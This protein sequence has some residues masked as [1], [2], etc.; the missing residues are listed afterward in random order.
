[1]PLKVGTI[2]PRS[3]ETPPKSTT[4]PPCTG[5]A[6]WYTA[7]PPAHPHNKHKP[8]TTISSRTRKI[9]DLPR[10]TT[11]AAPLPGKGGPSYLPSR[12]NLPPALSQLHVKLRG[13]EHSEE[14]KDVT[15][16][17]ADDLNHPS[18]PH[19]GEQRV[20]LALAIGFIPEDV[21]PRGAA[22]THVVT[23]G[24]VRVAGGCTSRGQT[25]IRAFCAAQL[26]GADRQNRNRLDIDQNTSH[27]AQK[28]GPLSV[29]QAPSLP[30]LRAGPVH[31]LR[32]TQHQRD[33]DRGLQPVKEVHNSAVGTT[34]QRRSRNTHQSA[35]HHGPTSG[36][37][38]GG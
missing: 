15:T 11:R 14:H 3:N 20:I 5:V 33:H 34:I 27:S 7:W 13:L 32:D 38:N 8:R 10:Q 36:T 29:P 35:H 12:A 9:L 30:A 6:R 1:M 22:L 21:T 28:C 23:V 4:A 31:E 16:P 18:L 37:Y 19:G 17:G 25:Q 26:P 24:R 2:T